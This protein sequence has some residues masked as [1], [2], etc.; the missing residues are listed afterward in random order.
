MVK[1]TAKEQARVDKLISE[2][3]EG[4]SR[5]YAQNLL[6]DGCVTMGG[7]VVRKSRVVLPGE[8]V[9]IEMPEPKMLETVAEDIPLD[10]VYEDSEL[11][12]VNKP[13]GMVVHPA[14]GNVR[15]TLVNALLAH[16]TLSTINGVVRPGIVHRIDKDTT[17][18]LLVAKTDN[19]HKSLAKQIKE[20]SLS[21]C[22]VVLV[23]GNIKAD[24]G[25]IDLPIARH[26]TARKKMAI[27]E[28]GRRAVTNYTVLERFGTYTLVECRLETGR[29]HQ[30]RVH[31]SNMGNPVV[32]DKT[33][34]VKKERFVLAGQLLHAKKLGFIH[35]KSGE[36]IECETDIPADFAKIIE[37]LRGRS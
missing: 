20:H 4:I 14:A 19:A 7:I 5:S 29:T 28:G 22:Y 10:I 23:H 32:G 37:V 13:R 9:C 15:G 31:M 35:P 16:C 12:V 34:G 6:N 21:R 36:M 18:L 17:G 30:I 11:L 8:E 26:R 1:I 33:Y 27:A 2:E 3:C 24:D 25:R